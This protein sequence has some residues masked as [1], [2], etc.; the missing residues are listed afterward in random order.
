MIT[1]KKLQLSNREQL[2]II[3]LLTAA[4]YLIG[5]HLTGKILLGDLGSI[6]SDINTLQAEKTSLTNL[7]EEGATLEERYLKENELRDQLLTRLPDLADLPRVLNEL[8][9]FLSE[10]PVTVNS[11]RI[12]DTLY[13]DHHAAVSMQ[14][15][16]SA[17]PF[18]QFSLLEQLELLPHIIYFDYLT[19][20]ELNQSDIDLEL[21]LYLLFYH[22]E[23][24]ESID[25]GSF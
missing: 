9:T 18:H 10:K 16:T 21:Q 6:R 1:L 5:W 4:L 17:A 24:E 22:P 15:K 25:G 12:G 20:N 11:L 19:W 3:I 13:Y 8:E 7:I 14:L 23:R 2:I